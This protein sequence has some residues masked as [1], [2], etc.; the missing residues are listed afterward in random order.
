MDEIGLASRLIVDQA[1][2]H[3]SVAP[4]CR[5]AAMET[6]VGTQLWENAQ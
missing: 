1:L 6:H 2:G 5:A 4:A 3:P